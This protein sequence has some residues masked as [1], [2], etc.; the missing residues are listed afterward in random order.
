MRTLQDL[1]NKVLE[2]LDEFDGECVVT[3]FNLKA[4]KSLITNI[5]NIDGTIHYFSGDMENDKQA[6]EIFPTDEEKVS[7][8][9]DFVKFV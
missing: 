6:E 8:L 2:I 3:G 5:V 4:Q 9:S 1:E 7:V